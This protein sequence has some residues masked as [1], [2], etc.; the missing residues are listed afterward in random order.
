MRCATG[1]RFR[2]LTLVDQFNRACPV[3]E[4]DLSLTGQR[5]ATTLER[6]AKT[7][8]IP[9]VITVDHG[10]EF[11]SKALD[12]WCHEHSVKLDF[13]LRGK[14]VENAYIESFNGRLRDEFLNVNEFLS[15]N[16]ARAKQETWRRDYNEQRPH[17]ALG[18]LTPREYTRTD[19]KSGLPKLEFSSSNWS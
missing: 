13:I 7:C 6:L 5:A 11:I 9:Q 14:P 2:I 3:L 16:D 19:Q 8:G 15:L 12:L 4:A 10:S 17:G 1:R 18:D